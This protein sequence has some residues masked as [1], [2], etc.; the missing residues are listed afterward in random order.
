MTTSDAAKLIKQFAAKVAELPPDALAA[1]DKELLRATGHK[2]WVPNIGPQKDALSSPADEIFFGGSAGS[3][4]TDLIVGASLTEHKRSLVLRR[5]YREASKLVDRYAEILGSRTGWNGQ[6]NVWRTH[7]GR[8]IDIAGVQLEDDK[9]KFKGTPR[10]LIGFDEISDFSESQYRFIITW[11]RSSDPNERCRVI[12]AGNPPTTPEGLWVIRYWAPWLDS[13]HPNPAKPGELRWFTTVAGKDTE[14]DGVGPHL[15]DGELVRARSRTFIPGR[16]ADN[17]SLSDSGYDAVLAALPE[18]LRRAYRDG[19]FESSLSDDEWQVIPS[20]WIVAAQERWKAGGGKPPPNVPMTAMGVDVAQGGAD[21][22]VLAFRHDAWFGRPIVVRG[23]ETPTGSDAAALIIKH[24][25]DGAAIIV[26]CGGGFG[27]SVIQR[28]KDNFLA[29]DDFN[30]A[31]KSG[32]R[33]KDRK[34]NFANRRAE[35]WWALREALDPDQH[36]GSPIELPDDPVIRADLSAP[37][38]QLTARG[39]LLEDKLEI[40][41]RIGRSPDVGDALCMCWDG[42]QGLARRAMGGGQA[43]N[44]F[45]KRP[46]NYLGDTGGTANMRRRLSLGAKH[47]QRTNNEKPTR[48]R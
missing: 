25:R 29:A 28:L 14:V 43:G 13:N 8:I 47:Q 46:D 7:D 41:K 18:E 23:S 17:P 37:R 26:D 31:H 2:V 10:S 40:K 15:I 33:T 9:Q 35:A 34:L 11:N 32:R 22:T 3:S 16:L 27:G 24:R 19:R 5:T 30:G 44:P 39:I 36:G 4:K 6:D 42:N 1:L 12:A 20:S 38:W 21:Q 48:Y 45:H